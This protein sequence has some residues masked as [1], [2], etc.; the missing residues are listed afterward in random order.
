MW[1]I[2]E[3]KNKK[4]KIIHKL[5]ECYDKKEREKL[6]FTLA[7][8]ISMLDNSGTIRYTKFY[9]LMDKITKNTFTLVKPSTKLIIKGESAVSKN[10]DYMDIDYLS[11]LLELCNNVSNTKKVIDDFSEITGSKISFTNEDLIKI[12]KLFYFNLGDKEIYEY[13]KKILDDK[14]ALNFTGE[15]ASYYKNACGITFF[16]YIYNK[17]YCTTMRNEVLFDL[18]ANNHEIMHGIDFYIKPKIPT[19]NYYGFHEV[20]TYTID[21]LFINYLDTLEFDKNEVQ[22]LRLRKDQYLQSLA[23]Q[24]NNQIK[25]Q[26]VTKKGLFYLKNFKTEDV[27]EVITPRILRNLLEIQSGVIAYGLSKQFDENYELG[28]NNLKTFMKTMISKNKR[29][30]FSKIGL[31]ESELINLSFE[32]GDYSKKYQ[33]N[34]NK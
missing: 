12:S 32:I 26:L 6:E 29:P 16:D 4:R 30:D 20:P 8:Y 21:Y 22:K 24:T 9:N 14:T 13:A 28:L 34:K 27:M 15:F 18:Q 23:V 5:K 17:A 10:K 25:N 7:T 11:F 3:I 31:S 2:E 33:K 1:N 19:E